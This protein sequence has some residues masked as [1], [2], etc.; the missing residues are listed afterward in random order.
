[1]CSIEVS[2]MINQHIYISMDEL[3]DTRFTILTMLYPEVMQLI[4]KDN[5]LYFSRETDNFEKIFGGN[6]KNIHYEKAYSERQRGIDAESVITNIFED[7][8]RVIQSLLLNKAI[9]EEVKDIVITINTYPYGNYSAEE[10]KTLG[11]IIRTITDENISVN[12][13]CKKPAL[14]WIDDEFDLVYIYDF[15]DLISSDIDTFVDIMNTKE[16]DRRTTYKTPALFLKDANVCDT[17]LKNNNIDR[18]SIRHSMGAFLYQF[19]IV[20][21]LDIEFFS[22]VRPKNL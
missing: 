11:S 7:L 1:M 14:K 9:K 12:F 3:L 22:C 2:Y 8:T 13:I 20:E 15:N 19:A 16:L 6:V 10:K 4:S 5:S 17:L 18:E 21:Q